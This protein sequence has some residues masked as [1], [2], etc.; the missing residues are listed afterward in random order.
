[1]LIMSGEAPWELPDIALELAERFPERAANGELTVEAAE[2]AFV[3]LA[4]EVSRRAMGR[5][6]LPHT[7][8]GVLSR[9]SLARLKPWNVSMGLMLENLRDDL[10]AHRGAYRKVGARRLQHIVD[11][12]E[13]R[14]PFTTGILVGIGESAADRR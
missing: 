3:D 7:N 11:A 1:V 12:G 6:L 4:I 5:G 9:R 14:I 8:L 13:M 2:D 10:K